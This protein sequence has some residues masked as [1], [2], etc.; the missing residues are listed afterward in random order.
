MPVNIFPC[1]FWPYSAAEPP[2]RITSDGPSNVLMIQNL[3]DPATP[4]SGAM[5]MRAAFGDRAR[6]V[7]VDSGGH[8]AYLANG[9][10]C[11]DQ[12]VT[13]FLVNGTRP[14][15]DVTCHS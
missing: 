15:L 10:A 1:A 8:G 2:V 6:L 3:R 14:D 9:D 11:G 13:A 5:K 4:Y 7:T 12:T